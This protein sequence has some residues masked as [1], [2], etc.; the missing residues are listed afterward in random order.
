MKLLSFAVAYTWQSC[1]PSGRHCRTAA[2]STATPFAAR[3]YRVGHADT[4]R[5]LRVTETAAET[6]E[7]KARRRSRSGSSGAPCSRLAGVPVRAYPRHQRPVSYFRNGT[8][9]AAHRL[10]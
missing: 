10:G 5:R 2:D 9:G 4:G 3:Q 1:A 7:T 8:A 6:V